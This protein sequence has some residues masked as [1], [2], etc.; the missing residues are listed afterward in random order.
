MIVWHPGFDGPKPAEGPAPADG[1]VVWAFLDGGWPRVVKAVFHD[2]P[3]H[4]RIP[5]EPPGWYEAPAAW[6]H[7]DEPPNPVLFT[8]W[9]DPSEVPNG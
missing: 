8:R 9:L 2:K 1:E 5:H 3:H 7:I 4:W 6:A